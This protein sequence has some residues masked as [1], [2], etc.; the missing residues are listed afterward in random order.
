MK[1]Q[2]GVVLATAILFSGCAWVELTD[3]GRAVRV[4]QSHEVMGCRKLGNTTVTIADKVG[5][6]QRQPHIIANNLETLARNAAADM[7]GDTVVAASPVTEGRQK[8]D[9]YRCNG[10]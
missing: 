6:L 2:Y 1:W 5:G 7:Q 10:N 8:F 3:Q 9:V 4:M